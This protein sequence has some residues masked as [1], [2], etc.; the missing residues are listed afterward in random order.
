MQRRGKMTTL[1]SWLHVPLALAALA[2]ACANKSAPAGSAVGGSPAGPATAP[3][4]I[5]ELRVEV[6]NSFPHDPNAFTQGLVFAGGKLYES[7]GLVGR[8][9]LRRVDFT[10]GK[11]EKQIDV[12]APIFSEGLALAG[13]ELFQ[14]SWQDGLVFVYQLGSFEKLREHRYVGEGWGLT[15]D[16]A[17]L[18]MSDG[19]SH[20]SFRDPKTF[21]VTGGV[22]VVRT[23]LPLRNLNELEWAGGQLWANVWQTDIIVRIDPASGEVTGW[24]DAKGLLSANDRAG[25]DV[26]NGIAFVPPRGTFFI[27]GKLWPRLFEVRFVPR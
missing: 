16:G 11:V 10:T 5:E 8:S 12:A 19:T 20:L 22:D 21:A 2:S 15:Y 17:R 24:V 4:R 7:T 6:V 13:D 9:S 25:T 27:T 1:F 18:I 23:G 3:G 14:L 26:L